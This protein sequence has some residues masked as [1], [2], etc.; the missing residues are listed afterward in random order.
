VNGFDAFLDRE[1]ADYN[2]RCDDADHLYECIAEFANDMVEDANRFLAWLAENN[3]Q[4]SEVMVTS[5]LTGRRVNARAALLAHGPEWLR[6]QIL[7]AEMVDDEVLADMQIMF[8]NRRWMPA[9]AALIST[10]PDWLKAELVDWLSK[11]SQIE[12][13]VKEEIED[14]ARLDEEDRAAS[15]WG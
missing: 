6:E 10:A 14:R 11:Q 3:W 12:T 13:E 7:D 9:D 5:S 4:L 15:R 2:R 8:A 1:L